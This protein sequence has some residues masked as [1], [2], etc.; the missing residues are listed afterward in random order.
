MY[1]WKK[2]KKYFTK[3]LKNKSLEISNVHLL[4]KCFQYTII[5][6]EYYTELR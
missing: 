2:N 4:T 1:V 6:L 3:Y 5:I